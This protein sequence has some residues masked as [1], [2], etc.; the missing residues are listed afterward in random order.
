MM[1]NHQHARILGMEDQRGAGY[2]PRTK[3]TGRKRLRCV[4]EQKS[5][6]VLTFRSQAIIPRIEIR[7]HP[8]RFLCGY[9]HASIVDACANPAKIK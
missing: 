1:V 9:Q 2:V 8:D 3:L 4:K 7:D 5:R 6:Q